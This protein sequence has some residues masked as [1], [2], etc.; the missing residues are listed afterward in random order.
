MSVGRELQR[1]GA[2]WLKALHPVVVKRA[3]GTVRPLSFIGS[4]SDIP[5][6]LEI[7]LLT[8]KTSYNRAPLSE[9][10]HMDT[11]SPH[12]QVFF[13]PSTSL[14]ILHARPPMGSRAFGRS[15]PP[16]RPSQ[17]PSF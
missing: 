12:S 17:N 9:L 8:F 14:H 16:T 6:F 4:R 2:E 15:A 10:L 5:L 3:G 7:L 11:P 13:L 1:Q